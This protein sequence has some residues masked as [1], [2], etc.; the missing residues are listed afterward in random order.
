MA[1]GHQIREEEEVWLEQMV[2]KLRIHQ[3]IG[4]ETSALNHKKAE[5]SQDSLRESKSRIDD[6]EEEEKWLDE[7]AWKLQEEN[8]KDRLT[9][10]LNQVTGKGD[11]VAKE[12]QHDL[13]KDKVSN[14]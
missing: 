14:P 9:C 7:I 13:K 5:E 6:L 1:Q 11:S 12:K 8:C 3:D 2:L 10:K 4:V